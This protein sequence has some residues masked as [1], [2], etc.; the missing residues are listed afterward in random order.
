V[1]RPKSTRMTP[2]DI[3]KHFV[4]QVRSRSAAVKFHIDGDTG[5]LSRN[6]DTASL[7]GRKGRPG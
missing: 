7:A 5:A 4:L 1:A 2:S 3:G 6:L